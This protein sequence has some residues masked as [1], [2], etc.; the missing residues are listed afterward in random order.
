MFKF[1]SFNHRL[2]SAEQINIS[3]VSSAVLYGKGIFSTVAVYNSAPFLWEKHWRRLVENARR[4]EI[5][6]A[7][8]SEKQTE[9]SLLELIEQNK[10]KNA[11]ARIT[12]FD[13]SP[14][15]IWKAGEIRK[16]SLLIIA[17]EFKKNVE[18]L[19]LTVSS[20]LINSTSPLANLKSCNYLENVLAFQKAKSE[21]Y[22]EAVRLNEKG[23]IVS[24]CLANIF[25][26]KA[27]KIFTPPIETGALHGTMR[28]FIM[29]NFEICEE[30]AGLEILEN[31]DAVFL[32]SA[33][34][35]ARRVKNLN[36]R[37]YKSSEIFEQ[38]KIIIPNLF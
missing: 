7:E 4:L 28:E 18:E 24:A 1:F 15:N 19:S 22:D 11:R 13:E 31:A 26:I 37:R 33:G 3:P 5:N 12:F 27:N 8:F 29:E 36:E 10:I 35:G 17:A 38:I 30:K 23:E 6:L 14:A 16:T 9:K 2:F 32:T 21:G 20:Y 25:W 34:I